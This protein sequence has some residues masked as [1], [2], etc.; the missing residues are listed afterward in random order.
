MIHMH[1]SRLWPNHLFDKV[2]R[3]EKRANIFVSHRVEDPWLLRL[4]GDAVLFREI[5]HHAWAKRSPRKMFDPNVA[6]SQ[7]RPIVEE[8]PFRPKPR[9]A[10]VSL[11]QFGEVADHIGLRGN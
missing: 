9:W 7:P 6:F 11:R 4:F 1:G 3:T 8:S 5:R 10:P 2:G